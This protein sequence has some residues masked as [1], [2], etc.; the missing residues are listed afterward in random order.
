[1]YMIYIYFES[2][3]TRGSAK[4]TLDSTKFYKYLNNKIIIL[5]MQGI[6]IAGNEEQKAKYLPRLATGQHVA[7]F[8]LTE[9]SRLAVRTYLSSQH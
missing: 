2:K 7:A 8:C 9:P 6:L 4:H 1:M 3:D 5:C